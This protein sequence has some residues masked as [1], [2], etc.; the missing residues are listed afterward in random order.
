MKIME[1]KFFQALIFILM[2]VVIFYFLASINEKTRASETDVIS[3]TGTGEIYVT[4]DIGLINISVLTQN[5]NV[6]VASTENSEKMN[7]IITYLKG[8]GVEEKDIKTTSFSI[9]PVYS[10]ED[11]TG[12]RSIDTYEVSQVLE[13][14][15]RDLSKV[16]DIISKSTE[17]GANNVSSLSFTIDDDEKV[18]EQAKEEAIKNAKEKAK[19]LEKALGV[20]LVKIVNFSEGTTYPAY[21]SY[22]KTA[23]GMGGAEMLSSVAPTIQTGQNKVTSTVTITYSVR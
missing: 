12:R 17:L 13:V 10:W 23:S 16:G 8:N 6:S 19:T 5:K 11:K 9:Y 2:I 20:H 1:N 4:P 15:I 22:Y 14:K 3:V 18:K 7:A 21:D